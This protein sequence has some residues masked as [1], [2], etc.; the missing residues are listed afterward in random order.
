MSQEAASVPPTISSHLNVAGGQDSLEGQATV[1]HLLQML[2]K[3]HSLLSQFK[4]KEAVAAFSVL[5][6]QHFQTAW[7]LSQVGKAHF[8]L[9]NY[10][11]ALHFFEW[12]RAQDPYRVEGLEWHS[13][14]LWHMKKEVC[15]ASLSLRTDYPMSKN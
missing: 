8:E 7:V 14:V 1:V 10:S 6:S 13:T 3:G 2:G 5:P 4:S 12:S 9:V 11:Q 15:L